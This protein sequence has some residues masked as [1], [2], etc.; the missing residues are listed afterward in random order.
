MK[1]VEK[2]RREL[3]KEREKVK[4]LEEEKRGLE[5]IIEEISSKYEA[6]ALSVEEIEKKIEEKIGEKIGEIEKGVEEKLEEVKEGISSLEKRLERRRGREP[7]A[8]VSELKESFESRFGIIEEQLK[9]LEKLSALED[10][11]EDLRK[12]LP[13]EGGKELFGGLSVSGIEKEERKESK[14]VETSLERLQEAFLET[15]QRIESKLSQMEKRISELEKLREIETKLEKIE[16]MITPELLQKM[17]N[18]AYSYEQSIPKRIE[19]EVSSKVSPLFD[20][21]KG[22][23]E[24]IVKLDQRINSSLQDLRSVREQ[25]EKIGKIGETFGRLEAKV[26][27]LE[28]DVR[29]SKGKID[30]INLNLKGIVKEE[31]KEEGREILKKLEEN[32]DRRFS[33]QLF[34]KIEEVEKKYSSLVRS[35][36]SILKDILDQTVKSMEIVESIRS[37]FNSTVRSLDKIKA[38]VEEVNLKRRKFAKKEEVERLKEEVDKLSSH[39]SSFIKEVNEKLE[40]YEKRVEKVIE[41]KREVETALKKQKEYVRLILKELEG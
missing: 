17:E 37:G 30:E 33:F 11:I 22:L 23:K 38:Q 7:E 31:L 12:K 40:E 26:E 36:E 32:I 13:E 6:Q 10:A 35:V 2:L 39:I 20:R 5:E 8:L 3:K 1:E 24:E 15:N 34:P 21:L 28:K 4:R 9:M 14:E 41:E 19:E 29:K 18:I 16:N 27:E 25:L